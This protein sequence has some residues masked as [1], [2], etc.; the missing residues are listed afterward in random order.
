MR[1]ALADELGGIDSLRLGELPDPVPAAGLGSRPLGV[2]SP[3]NH[4]FVLSLGASD[5]FDYHD[6]DW[7]Q[8]VRAVVPGGVDLL[9][10]AAGRQTRD[11]AVSAVRDGGRAVS[12]LL[13]DAP[14]PLERGITFDTFGAHITRQ[15]LEALTRLVDDSK[16]HAQIAA[17]FPLEEA[18]EALHGSLAATPGARSS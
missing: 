15:R 4:D 12:I 3:A 16:L 6:A 17:V 5:V 9:L 18:R 13:A 1:V 10:D 7:V 14:P 11:Q 2:A 8:Q